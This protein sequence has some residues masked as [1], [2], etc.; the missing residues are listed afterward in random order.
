MMKPIKLM[1]FQC[2]NLSQF[3][4]TNLMDLIVH[5]N[6]YIKRMPVINNVYESTNIPAII[7]TEMDK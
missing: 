7:D 3:K 6:A 1:T 4:T 2:P 5:Y